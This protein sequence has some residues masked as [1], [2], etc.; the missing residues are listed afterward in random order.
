MI[1]FALGLVATARAASAD[2]TQHIEGDAPTDGPEH[3]WVPF[4][5]PDGTVEIE[6]AHDDG[7][8]TNILDWGVYDETGTFRGYGGGNTENAIIGV[9][10]SSRSYLIGAGSAGSRRRSRATCV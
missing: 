3:F 8:A 6:I 7:S 9:Q 5:V 2:T 10:A 1:A 4:Q